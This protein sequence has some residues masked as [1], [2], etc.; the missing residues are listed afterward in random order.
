MERDAGEV[1]DAFLERALLVFGQE[2]RRVAQPRH[3]HPFHAADDLRPG[4]AVAVRHGGE[5]IDPSARVERDVLLVVHQHRLEHLGRQAAELLRDLPHQHRRVLDEVAPLEAQAM[6]VEGPAH[7]GRHQPLVDAGGAGLGLDQD[8]TLAQRLA[9]LGVDGHGRALMASALRQEAV[10]AR[11]SAALHDHAALGPRFEGMDRERHHPP[12][13]GH[14]QPADRPP[15]RERPAAVLEPGIPAH[16]LRERERSQQAGQQARHELARGAARDLLDEEQVELAGL[17]C[18]LRLLDERFDGDAILLREALRRRGP[19]ARGVF[20][21]L[22]RRAPDRLLAIGLAR[23]QL[24][25]QHQPPRRPGHGR[26]LRLQEL[27]CGCVHEPRAQLL[28][29]AGQPRRRHLLEADLDQELR[30]ARP[31]QPR[32]APP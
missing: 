27:A 3:H 1:G 15:E 26:V 32:P 19:G 7:G 9:Q 31:R 30:H 25:A 8:E 4:C 13:E 12:V 14:D 11:G 23:G 10:A 6:V 5:A 20:R 24:G 21:D 29:E 18:V 2:E 16:A 17:R 28:R 22:Q